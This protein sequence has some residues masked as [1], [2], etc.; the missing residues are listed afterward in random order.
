MYKRQAYD[1]ANMYAYI[2]SD[3]VK[4]VSKG[5]G[6]Q[7]PT[8]PPISKNGWAI[9]EGKKYYYENGKK[10]KGRKKI[11]GVWY[12]FETS[13]GAMQTGWQYIGGKWYYMNG[14]GAMQTGWQYIG[15][16]W[17]YMN[18]SGAM[19]TGWQYIG[20]KWYYMNGSGAMQIG[21]QYIGG[22]WYFLE[23]SG[24]M[25]TKKWIGKYYVNDSGVWEK[26]KK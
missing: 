16:K 5:N 3:Y 13:T 22:K 17:Y 6:S 10:V 1:F 9:E 8:E 15:G 7:T 19:Q 18:G 12:Y 26:N 2:S 14:S 25:A 23:S 21:W 11:E 24:K 20:G 4:I